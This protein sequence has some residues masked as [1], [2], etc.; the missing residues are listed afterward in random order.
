MVNRHAERRNSTPEK[1]VEAFGRLGI[2]HG[3][4]GQAAEMYGALVD[5]EITRVYLQLGGV[6]DLDDIARAVEAARAAVD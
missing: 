1:V 6:G 3:P 2:P 4:V 5:E